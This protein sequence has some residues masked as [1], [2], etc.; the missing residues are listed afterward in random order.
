MTPRITP[1]PVAPI[2]V[3][4]SGAFVECTDARKS[5]Y[6]MV[7]WPVYPPSPR[8][9]AVRELRMRTALGLGSAARLFGV[10][11]V[12]WSGLERG[13]VTLSD[14]DWELVETELRERVAR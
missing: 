3:R 10:S 7:D 8:G 4:K 9:E 13:G 5:G 6:Q 14:G 12:T 1:I 2:A 11:V